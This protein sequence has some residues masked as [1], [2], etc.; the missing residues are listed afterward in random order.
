MNHTEILTQQ[1]R[2][3]D[4]MK[5]RMKANLVEALTNFASAYEEE[6]LAECDTHTTSDLASA[7]SIITGN[8][9]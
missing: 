5:M 1:Q 6:K 9:N 7:L 4:D 3:M 8:S 2:L